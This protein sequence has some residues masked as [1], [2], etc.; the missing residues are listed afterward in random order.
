MS[1]MTSNI[2]VTGAAGLI[3]SQVCV[4]LQHRGNAVTRLVHRSSVDTSIGIPTLTGDVRTVICR[5]IERVSPDV[6]I[7]CAGY[8]HAV[9][10]GDDRCAEMFALN[11]DGSLNLAKACRQAGVKR[12][13]FLSSVKAVSEHSGSDGP[14]RHDSRLKPASAYGESKAQAED[15]LRRV[16]N[17]SEMELL[18]IRPPMVYSPQN[19]G[20]MLAMLRLVDLGLPIPFGAINNRRS[21]VSLDNL[22]SF[23]NLCATTSETATGCYMVSDGD[24]V[25][26]SDIF[27]ALIKCRKSKS[28]LFDG[29]VIGLEY[30]LRSLGLKALRQRLYGSLEVDISHTTDTLGWAPSHSTLEG[31]ASYYSLR[32]RQE[33]GAGG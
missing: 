14:L 1:V 24:S 11:V 22:V 5:D 18:I 12:F 27:S 20:N 32:S 23:I 3:G 16:V 21:M 19:K 25:S 7:H 31:L 13:V 28:K 6:V 15:G 30:F 9:A 4:S 33:D 8:K 10:H 29:R 2:L 17:G 26:T